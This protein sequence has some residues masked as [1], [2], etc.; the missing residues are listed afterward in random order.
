M[1]LTLHLLCGFD[2]DFVLYLIYRPSNECA[3]CKKMMKPFAEASGKVDGVVP[4]VAIDC[5]SSEKTCK[6]SLVL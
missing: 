6:V 5:S 3:G 1:T 4:L 2:F